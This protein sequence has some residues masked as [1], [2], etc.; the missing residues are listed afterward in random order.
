MCSTPAGGCLFGMGMGMTSTANARGSL[1]SGVACGLCAARIAT[2]TTKLSRERSHAPNSPHQP[3]AAGD[4]SLHRGPVAKIANF[5]A[6]DDPEC[7]EDKSGTY[8][9][10]AAPW[11]NHRYSD[12]TSPCRGYTVK[13]VPVSTFVTRVSGQ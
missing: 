2:F 5:S 7:G 6:R 3:P 10:A 13:P 8:V 4:M 9:A 1:A 12:M 11:P